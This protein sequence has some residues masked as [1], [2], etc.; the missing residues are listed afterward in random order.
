MSNS[1]KD[2]VVQETT[3][4]E[5]HKAMEE[6]RLTA[7]E[8]V[9]AYLERIE[10]YDKKGPSLNSII[11]V[12]PRAL[13]IADELDKK[14][15][16]TG[17]VGPL[18]G[19]PVMLKDNVDTGDME[20]TAG[21]LSLEGVIPPDDAF[22]TRK[23]KEGGA[24]ILAK[25]NLHEFAVW[26]E[27]IS[28]ILGQT[29]NPYDLARTPGGSSGGTG[30]S[31]AANLGLVGIGTDTINSIR[32]PASACSLV[33]FR[34]TIG[35]VS[36][37]GVVP[38]SLTQDTAGPITRTVEDAARVLDVISGYD[39]ADSITGWS[40]GRKPKSFL[41]SLK[42]NGLEGKRIGILK[43]FFGEKPEHREVNNLVMKSLKEM[44]KAGATL[45]DIDENIDSDYLVKEVSVHMYD[46]K[47]HLGSYL[48]SLGELS[49][50]H[51]LED[52]IN[53]GK[54]HEGLH[55][56]LKL[57]QSLDVDTPIYN[58][59]LIKRLTLRNQVV[60]IMAELNLDVIA[61]PHQKIPVV[62]T[63]EAQNERNG[64]LGSV[65]GFPACSLPAG[66]TAPTETAPIG[67]PVGIEILA[68]E[69]DDATLMEI[70]YSFEQA[71]HHRK[72]PLS[73]P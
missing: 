54:Y 62:F 52:V 56:N 13:E 28:S 71:T 47:A 25:V 45:V 14:F 64:V 48:A 32:S 5:V 55:D 60:A 68:R 23:L 67:V 66:F 16:E 4:K 1:N 61:Y 37:D 22:L 10:A 11:K 57:A 24:I 12:N 19:I 72:A 49:Q 50:V 2:F 35:L 15:K 18:H 40:V 63:G 44:E 3:I 36:R 9:E 17:F 51:S 69:F 65:T 59:R 8:L 33:G 42:V 58:E 41:D 26:G 6:G 43:S 38:Y 70:A 39:A 53:S 46:L 73:T 27:T 7:R 29:L 34:P 30:A 31:I 21:S 20:T